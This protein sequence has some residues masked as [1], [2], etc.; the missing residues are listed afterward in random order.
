MVGVLLL[1]YETHCLLDIDQEPSRCPSVDFVW[2]LSQGL[3][4]LVA[5]WLTM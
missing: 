4:T 2:E 1:E 3:V 5:R